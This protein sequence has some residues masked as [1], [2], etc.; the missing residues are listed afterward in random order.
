MSFSPQECTRLQ[1][2]LANHRDGLTQDLDVLRG[3]RL[4][5]AAGLEANLIGG[6]AIHPQYRRRAV[7]HGEQKVTVTGR[8]TSRQDNRVTIHYVKVRQE[9]AGCSD[10]KVLAVFKQGGRSPIARLY[11]AGSCL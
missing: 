6:L 7:D 4:R 3:D 5:F 1:L 11:P 10:G 8:L 2:E 9:V